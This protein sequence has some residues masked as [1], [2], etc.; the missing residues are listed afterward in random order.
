VAL[1][2]F[3]SLVSVAHPLVQL[4]VAEGTSEIDGCAALHVAILAAHRFVN[5][6]HEIKVRQPV[7]NERDRVERKALL[8][9]ILAGAAGAI[10]YSDH[11]VGD[12]PRFRA[13]ACQARAEGVVSKR[14]DAVYSPRDRGLWRKSKCLNREEFVI[15]G[16]TDPEGS[17]PY[18]GAL[19][20]GYYTFDGKLVYG[21]ACRRRDVRGRTEEAAHDAGTARDQQDAVAA[22]PPKTNR[23]G[24]PLKLSRLHWVRPELVA[25]VTFLSWTGDGL[26]RQVTYQ[27]LRDDKAPRDVRRPN[28]V[29]I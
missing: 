17:R 7:A 1:A 13:A 2:S 27:G 9:L 10:R 25:E 6:L 23:F 21:G 12:G 24:A 15:V 11:F 26:L 18:L 22:P 29:Y 20:L 28:P 14:M 4:V 8:D 19:L 5:L 16:W 3:P